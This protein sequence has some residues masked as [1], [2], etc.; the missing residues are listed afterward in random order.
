M[1]VMRQNGISGPEQLQAII[2]EAM[3]CDPHVQ[4]CLIRDRNILLH[5]GMMPSDPF[6]IHGNDRAQTMG[7]HA[8]GGGMGGG[9]HERMFDRIYETTDPRDRYSRGHP[10]FDDDFDDGFDDEGRHRASIGWEP[11]RRTR[12]NQQHF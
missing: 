10:T 8:R 9:M 4:R 6:I 2:F 12:R 7:R 11:T 3:P 5:L 1:Q